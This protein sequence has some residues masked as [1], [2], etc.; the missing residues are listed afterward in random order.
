[1]SFEIDIC[2]HQSL[3]RVAPGAIRR[4]IR[5][6]LRAERV[7]GAVVSVTIVDNAAIHKINRKHLQHDYP[8]D[9]ISFSL[10]FLPGE[11]Y[12]EEDAVAVDDA[13]RG[14]RNE[15]LPA[16][17]AVIE[18]EIIASAEM[19]LQMAPECGWSADSELLLYVVHGLLHLCGYDDLT[20]EDKQ[21]MRGREQEIM[22]SMGLKVVYLR[23]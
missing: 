20:P 9:V 11:L 4:A 15:G 13:T 1:M 10:E 16:A 5:K 14:G 6:A 23:E 22:G 7:R 18:G 17:G 2:N 19:A 8:T 12:E 21:V 3:L